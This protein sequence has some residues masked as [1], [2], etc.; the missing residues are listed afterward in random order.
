MP[1]DDECPEERNIV[2]LGTLD[3]L[4]A[5]LDQTFLHL[6]RELSDDEV[7]ASSSLAKKLKSENNL[8]FQF[9]RNRKQ[10]WLKQGDAGARF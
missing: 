5:Y 3:D 6:K 10:F 7:K 1:N 9:S 2:C 8:T 4:K